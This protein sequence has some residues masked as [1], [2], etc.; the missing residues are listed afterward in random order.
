M[1]NSIKYYLIGFLINC[2]LIFN[3]NAFEQ[4]E[5]NVT[6]IEILENGNKIKGLDRGKITTNDGSVIIADTFL[7]NKTLNQLTAN[8]NIKI[9]DN[10]TKYTI[11]AEYIDYFKNEEKIKAKGKV[12]IIDNQKQTI[13]SDQIIF[14]KKINLINA[15]GNVKLEN[16]INKYTI[17][18][19]DISYFKNKQKILTKGNSRAIIEKKYEIFSEDIEFDIIEKKLRSDKKTRIINDKT[20]IINLDRFYF[21]IDENELKGENILVVSNF[22][23][24]KS[25]KFYFS[26]AILNLNKKSF[27][28]KSTEIK[29]HKNI[30]NNPEND[31][32]IKGVSAKG[33]NEQVTLNKAIFTTC[34]QN[35]DCPPWSLSARKIKHEKN[36]KQI[37][38]DSA[39][40]KIYDL[41]IMYF[42][43]FFHPD[44]SVKRQSGLLQP[45]LNNSN[46]LGNSLTIPYYNVIS[47]D[48]DNTVIVS[49]FDK[50]TKMIQNEYRQIGKNS[51]LV[52]D[53]GLIRNYKPLDSK[54]KNVLHL[55]SNFNYD[56]NFNKF[57]SSKLNLTIERINNDTYLKAFDSVI[58]KTKAKP[59]N[60][61]LLTNQ[62][63]LELDHENYEFNSGINI[64]EDLTKN[65]NDRYQ[66]VLPF[67]NYNT[68]VSNNFLNGVTN[69]SSFGSNDLN[70]TNNLKSKIVN[71]INYIG[72]N[73]ITN[74]GFKNN[75]TVSLKNLNSIGKKDSEYKSTPQVELMGILDINTSLPLISD[76][77]NSIKFLTPKLK[78]KLNPNDMKNYFDTDRK[79]NTSTLFNSN[80]LGLSDTLESGR[81]LT[82]GLD[83]K[84]QNKIDLN[85]FFEMK[86]ATMFRDKEENFIP[87]NSTLGKKNSN[88]FGTLSNN[89][90]EFINVKYDFAIDNN[91]KEFEYNNI[92]TTIS[93]NNFIT[94]FDFIEESG[95][96]GASNIFQNETSYV[97]DDK[98]MFSFKTRRNRKLNLTEYY[99]LI[100]QYNNDC[101]TAS[102]K[103]K[104]SYYEDRALKPSE[105]IFFSITLFPLTT[106]EQK[107]NK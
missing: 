15:K 59:K 58:E 72:K 78:L 41:P 4:F 103:Y 83:Y 8:G 49:L 22:G 96:M 82:L 89:L 98:N 86:L 80:R 43:K 65:S 94:K 105:D 54:N 95:L 40:L 3:I 19:E 69:F 68:N 75:L 48:K 9:Q 39:V 107:V 7:Y 70:N 23:S 104:K 42:P 71:D 10:L 46:I 47:E 73:F 13:T 18:A 11:F 17:F 1:K 30:F 101:L 55:F 34:K 67:Y 91:Y 61:D 56:L 81:S 20:Q 60:T 102:I 100:Y 63:L 77:K 21:S 106:Y 93:V 6:E 85:K 45:K 14:D 87:E 53:L 33:N 88:L 44:P 37:T 57:N 31:P 51:S 5:F 27:I 92:N 62:L 97:I 35:D 26:S 79:M 84:K 64:Y 90:N 66:Y 16:K 36:K 50:G 29:I 12:K 99:D 24:P 28:A 25:D 32:R 38:Y 2:I 52:A 74:Y 76:E